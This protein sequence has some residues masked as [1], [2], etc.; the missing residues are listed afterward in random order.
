MHLSKTLL[1]LI[2]C[3]SFALSLSCGSTTSENSPGKCEAVELEGVNYCVWEQKIIVETGYECPAETQYFHNIDDV[4]VC[5][6]SETPP[7]QK[8]VKDLLEKLKKGPDMCLSLI[9]DYTEKIKTLDTSCTIDTDC[10]AI[11]GHCGLGECYYPVNK[12]ADG[13]ALSTLATSYESQ[14]CGEGALCGCRPANLA[15]LKCDQGTCVED[16]TDQ[17]CL[18][19][20]KTYQDAIAALDNSCTMDTDCKGVAGYCGLASCVYAVNSNAD[21]TTMDSALTDYQT[22]NCEG[23]TPPLCGCQDP[24]SLQYECKA[25]ICVEIQ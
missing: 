2:F 12:S 15:I 17:S 18:D 3:A 24:G 5:S 1:S 14:D 23:D 8:E 22:Q 7:T 6:E 19:I 4:A 10:K 20:A 13:A 25:N 11:E 9:S 21:T 16:L